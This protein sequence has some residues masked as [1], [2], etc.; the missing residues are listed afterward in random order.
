M[1]KRAVATIG[2]GVLGV[3]E[4]FFALAG[5][6]YS[7]VFF[8]PR[9]VRKGG[10]FHQIENTIYT[11]IWLFV[12]VVVL[13]FT[14]HIIG[15]AI[16]IYIARASRESRKPPAFRSIGMINMVLHGVM[17][18]LALLTSCIFLLTGLPLAALSW[19]I[20]GV[21]MWHVWNPPIQD[22]T[23]EDDGLWD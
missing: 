3:L 23:E 14:V 22:G 11:S 21:T 4:V 10:E 13:A 17:G 2:L 18:L 5:I 20:A 8:I 19:L 6:L 15:G 7:L 1:Q 16:S 9:D 12:G